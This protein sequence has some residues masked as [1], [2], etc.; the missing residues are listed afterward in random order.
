MDY[1]WFYILFA[2]EHAERVQNFGV[3]Q[4]GIFIVLLR[5]LLLLVLHKILAPVFCIMKS[6]FNSEKFT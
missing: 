1:F 4:G 5:A 6:N 3:K 2:I